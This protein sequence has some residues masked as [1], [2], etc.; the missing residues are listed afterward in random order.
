MDRF[1]LLNHHFTALKNKRLEKVSTC[2][3]NTKS[4]VNDSKE[5]YAS[6]RP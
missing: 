6:P 3:L 2:E 4:Y 1:F 5:T